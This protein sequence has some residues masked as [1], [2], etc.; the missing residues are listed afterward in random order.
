MSKDQARLQYEHI[1]ELTGERRTSRT[2]KEVYETPLSVLIR[3]GW[4][5]VGKLLE[6][7]EYELLLTTGGPAVRIR[8]QLNCGEPVT[9]ELQH[10]DW[11]KPWQTYHEADEKV[12]LSFVSYFYFGE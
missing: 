5:E 3:S 12:L 11:F 8:G 6:A 10:Q 9:A 2:E 7:E 1:V 4:V